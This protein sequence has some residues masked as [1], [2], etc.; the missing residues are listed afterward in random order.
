MRTNASAIA[1]RAC[2]SRRN[3]DQVMALA[4]RSL[5][6]SVES[7]CNSDL[8]EDEKREEIATSVAQ[9]Q[10]YLQKNLASVERGDEADLEDEETGADDITGGKDHVVSR[11]ADLVAEAHGCD[12]SEALRWLLGSK[13]GHALV[14]TH[15]KKESAMDTWQSIAKDFGVMRSRK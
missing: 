8:S 13:R 6:K 5:R 14:R 11:L 4:A 7:I 15:A 12:R 9:C 3:R 10:E 1:S 2:A